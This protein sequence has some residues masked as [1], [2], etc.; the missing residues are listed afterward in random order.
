V[1]A[2]AFGLVPDELRR[3]TA[4]RLVELIRSAGTHLGTGFLATPHLLPVLADHG[5]AGVAYELL[6]QDTSPSWLSMLDRGATTMWEWWDGVDADGRPH[7]SLN[8]YAKGAVIGFLHRHTAGIRLGDDPA[9]RSFRIEPVPGGG[10]ASAS[11]AHESPYGRIESAWTLVDGVL[12]LDV[13]V[14]P[15]TSAEVVLPGG[16][17]QRVGPGRHGFSTAMALPL[18]GSAVGTEHPRGRSSVGHP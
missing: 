4:D 5:H 2:L 17:P 7:D 13:L 9:Y 10:L 15:G 18:N 6:L 11:A 12:R 16:R 14:P 8:H 1:R 3:P